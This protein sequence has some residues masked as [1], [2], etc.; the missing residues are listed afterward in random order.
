MWGKWCSP[1]SPIQLKWPFTV[2]SLRPTLHRWMEKCRFRQICKQY[3]RKMGHFNVYI[4]KSFRSLSKTNC[5]YF[6]SV[7]RIEGLVI[8]V[9]LNMRLYGCSSAPQPPPGSKILTNDI[10]TVPIN[11]TPTL[12]VDVCLCC[13][14]YN[15][16]R[17]NEDDA[18]AARDAQEVI[19]YASAF[20]GILNVHHHPNCR[21][22]QNH[23]HTSVRLL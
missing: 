3:L 16:N 19:K 17:Y 20:M 8:F 4:E 5:F 2:D 23:L 22:S 15:C 9:E 12:N 14:R 13:F 1:P 6:S 10:F 18:K 7:F 11:T 21:T